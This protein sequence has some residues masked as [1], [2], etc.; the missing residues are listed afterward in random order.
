MLDSRRP[1]GMLDFHRLAG[2]LDFRHLAGILD[3][4]RLIHEK[5]K[6]SKNTLILM[7]F[8]CTF[9]NKKASIPPCFFN[10]FGLKSGGTVPNKRPAA[11]IDGEKCCN[12]SRRENH[13]I[14]LGKGR[15]TQQPHILVGGAA[16]TRRRR[17]Q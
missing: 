7:L 5:Q 9:L 11:H 1:I 12:D 17:L 14:E 3:F 13:M 16:M 10:L 6:L 8:L 4:R 2:M 15:V